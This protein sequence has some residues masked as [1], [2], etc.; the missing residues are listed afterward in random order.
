MAYLLSG[1]DAQILPERDT[2]VKNDLKRTGKDAEEGGLIYPPKA[3]LVQ[4]SAAP[5]RGRPFGFGWFPVL[6]AATS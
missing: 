6:E 2:D 4:Q 1:S 3:D 5:D